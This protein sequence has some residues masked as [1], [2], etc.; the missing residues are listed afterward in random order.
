MLDHVMVPINI[1]LTPEEI[2]EALEGAGAKNVRRLD[3]GCDFD[4]VEHIH[5]NGKYARQ[6]FGVGEN[7]FVFSK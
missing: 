3:R 4:R 7:R 2:I 6:Y 1:R 5:R